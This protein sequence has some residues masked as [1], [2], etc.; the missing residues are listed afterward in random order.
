MITIHVKITHKM[1]MQIRS[2]LVSKIWETY[3][4]HPDRALTTTVHEQLS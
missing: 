2:L 4:G 1:A 3:T